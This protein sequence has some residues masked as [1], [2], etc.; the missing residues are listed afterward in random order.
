MRKIPH[1]LLGGHSCGVK[2]HYKYKKEVFA[3]QVLA[4]AEKITSFILMLQIKR[5][6]FM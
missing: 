5:F 6:K 1:L 2:F 4:I 3:K